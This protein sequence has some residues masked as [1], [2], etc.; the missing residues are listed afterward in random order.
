MILKKCMIAVLILFITFPFAYAQVTKDQMDN[1]IDQ[2]SLRHPFY[3]SMKKKK[4]KS[5]VE[6]KTILNQGI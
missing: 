6:F 4:P 1:S 3:T 2:K 5:L